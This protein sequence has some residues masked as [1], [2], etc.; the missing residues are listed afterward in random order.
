MP[1]GWAPCAGLEA[2]TPRTRGG[3]LFP[4]DTEDVWKASQERTGL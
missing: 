2:G 4:A 3:I 1:Q